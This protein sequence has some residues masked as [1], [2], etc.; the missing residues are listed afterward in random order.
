VR[1]SA[2]ED[3]VNVLGKAKRVRIYV[4]EGDR[5]G[6]RP[7]HLAILELLRKENAQ[8]ATV[9]RGIEGF[10]AT[11]I[12]HTTLLV[13]VAHDLPMVV[14]WV[15]RTE[16]VERL[17]ERLKALVPH[18]LITVDDTEIVHFEPHPIRDV[19]AVLTAVDVMTRE[20]ASV[21]GATPL[22]EVVALMLG[23]A[24]RALPVVE[25]G[26][27][28]G[29]IT[30]GDL[31]TR[32]GLDVRLDLIPALETSQRAAIPSVHCRGFLFEEPAQAPARC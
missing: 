27:P 5:V 14:E 11:G 3:P 31:V 19:S 26:K 10:G 7:T 13:D 15:D 18:G 9:L 30:N 22:R 21:P 32:G 20:V 16:V 25:A 1:P 8:G 23:K 2:Q 6:H 24:H 4:N 12:V 17:L 28:V 29:I